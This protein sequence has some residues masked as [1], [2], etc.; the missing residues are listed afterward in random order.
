MRLHDYWRSGAAYRVRIALNLKGVP[1]EQV[2]HDLRIGE[3][4][5]PDYAALNPQK[6][7]PALE[8]GGAVLIQSSAIIEWLDEVYPDPP[9]LPTDP[10]A[11][12]QARGMA[13]L[14]VSDIHP[15]VN[16]RVQKMLRTGLSATDEQVGLWMRH[17]I[18]DGFEALEALVGR[19]GG[20]FAFGDTPTLVDCCLVPQLYSAERYGV[21]LD[22]FPKL[23]AAGT[24]ARHL[25]AFVAA[26]PSNQPDGELA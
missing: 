14:V 3:Q 23:V 15:I 26:D 20:R 25:P 16:L 18:A 2:S 1:Y 6:L 10:I 9:L 21:D 17:W 13:Q 5:A 12:V 11:R 19:D 8:I 4:A 24:A 7:V 22:G